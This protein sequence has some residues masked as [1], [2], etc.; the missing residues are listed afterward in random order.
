VT[1]LLQD[2]G[3]PETPSPLKPMTPVERLQSDFTNTGFS[4]GAHPMR[5]YREALD[6]MRVAPAAKVKHLRDGT[7]IR[8]AGMVICRQQPQTAKGFVF[9]S[10]E[11]ETG[12]VNI[13]VKPDVFERQRV[14]VVSHAYLLIHG[15]LQNQRGVASVKANRVLPC[16]MPTTATATSH[17][18]R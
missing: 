15:V 3:L 16:P 7:S 10:L 1:E 12:I 4:I 9:L 14:A 8:V 11:D 5:F 6:R 17:D 2:A 18:F 13:I